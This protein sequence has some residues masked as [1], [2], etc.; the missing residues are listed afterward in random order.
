MQYNLVR[1]LTLSACALAFVTCIKAQ[2]PQISPNAGR[3]FIVV[4]DDNF[5]TQKSKPILS[6][7]P[8]IGYEVWITTDGVL[9]CKTPSTLKSASI[10]FTAPSVSSTAANGTTTGAEGDTS[11]KFELSK[12]SGSDE[13]IFNIAPDKY[14][15]KYSVTLSIVSA[16]GTKAD[17]T[18]INK[19]VPAEI[20]N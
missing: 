12:A 18:L 4:T 3:R 6:T 1:I 13:Y 5:G 8:Q 19:K 10:K 14:R 16:S 20:K 15:T 9:H 7:R 11:R 17:I 2:I